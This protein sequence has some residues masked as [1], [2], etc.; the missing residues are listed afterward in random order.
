MH[1]GNNK[2]FVTLYFP[3]AVDGQEKYGISSSATSKPGVAEG[4]EG[5]KE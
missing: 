5:K 1:L 2:N 4:G 3:F